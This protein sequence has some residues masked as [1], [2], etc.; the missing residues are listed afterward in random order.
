MAVSVFEHEPPDV[1][2]HGHDVTRGRDK[3]RIGFMTCGCPAA[4]AQLERG[5]PAGHHWLSCNRCED[6]G[7]EWLYYDPPHDP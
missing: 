2:P 3:R 4:V 1:C 5:Y 7:A 6:A